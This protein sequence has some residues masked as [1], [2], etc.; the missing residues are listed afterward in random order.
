MWAV[1]GGDFPRTLISYHPGVMTMRI[2]GLRT[3]FVEPR[4]D[5]PNLALARWFIGVAVLIGLAVAMELSG[6][7]SAK[8]RSIGFT[9]EIIRNYIPS[10]VG[11][12]DGNCNVFRVSR[13]TLS[14]H[15]S[16]CRLIGVIGLAQ[17]LVSILST[18]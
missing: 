8:V 14:S 10:F 1:K 2:A 3:F 16:E 12:M 15:L 4:V 7:R 5:V 6:Q 13:Q 9:D 17:T 11:G 18:Q